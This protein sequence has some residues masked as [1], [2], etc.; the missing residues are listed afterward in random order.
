MSAGLA[1]R[2]V[3]LLPLR[4][5]VRARTR[6]ARRS[7]RSRAAVLGRAR[8][9]ATS[10]RARRSELRARSAAP[11]LASRVPPAGAVRARSSW[12]S[13]RVDLLVGAEPA[14]SAGGLGPRGARSSVVARPEPLFRA[15][16]LALDRPARPA[17]ARPQ[18]A[19]RDRAPA[20]GCRWPSALRQRAER[21]MA[22]QERAPPERRHQQPLR[23]PA[24][25]SRAWRGSPS[26]A[27][28]T[29]S[30][31]ANSSFETTAPNSAVSPAAK[32][33]SPALPEGR[34]QARP[35]APAADRAGSSIAA[36]S[37]RSAM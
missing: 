12:R 17:P 21:L 34:A 7:P 14:R 2:R 4:L 25:R 30:R 33:G 8:A 23:P 22:A 18:P 1:P 9:L 31:N 32:H 13:V 3:E 19:A 29:P 6:Q 5:D 24:E 27:S 26:T 37:S 28:T 15:S 11:P 36:G 10:S 16:V 20:A 35:P